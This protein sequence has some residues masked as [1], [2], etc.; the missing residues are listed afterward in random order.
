MVQEPH[1]ILWFDLIESH[2]R[3]LITNSCLIHSTKTGIDW[4]RFFFPSFLFSFW[5]PKSALLHR[6]SLIFLRYFRILIIHPFD[7][8]FVVFFVVIWIVTVLKDLAHQDTSVRRYD[9]PFHSLL[10]PKLHDK[11]WQIL[12][13]L[14]F[15]HFL[16]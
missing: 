9:E 10:F 2:L 4:R 12:I 16:V 11:G 7:W 3:G 15:N 6:F 1:I 5:H 8:Y 14:F 13:L